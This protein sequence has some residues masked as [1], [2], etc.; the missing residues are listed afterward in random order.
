M[1]SSEALPNQQRMKHIFV[2]CN[3]MI[4]YMK[5]LILII[6]IISVENWGDEKIGERR[7]C[8]C[9]GYDFIFALFPYSRREGK[10][11]FWR[12]FT[13]QR[14]TVIKHTHLRNLSS[15]ARQQQWSAAF[16]ISNLHLVSRKCVLKCPN[17]IKSLCG[18]YLTREEI[19]SSTF[20]LGF[21]LVLLF[22]DS[23][24]KLPRFFCV[25]FPLALPFPSRA[26]GSL[27]CQ[28]A[29]KW[30]SQHR[31]LSSCSHFC[32]FHVPHPLHHWNRVS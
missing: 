26:L 7:K 5:T 12:E 13:T 2:Q 6:V 16:Q 17:D 23:K 20:H 3:L 15:Q 32:P 24:T 22:F 11:C 1:G 31:I 8:S 18:G 10:M 28:S 14:T 27:L 29:N 9:V 4:G 30:R 25:A 19:D 21:P